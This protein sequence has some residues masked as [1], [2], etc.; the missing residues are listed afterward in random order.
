M[1]EP[2][3]EHLLTAPGEPGTVSLARVLSQV[4]AG[5]LAHGRESEKI[6]RTVPL[7]EHLPPSSERDREFAALQEQTRRFKIALDYMSQGLCLFDADKRLIIS[8]RRYAEIYGLSPDQIH[9]GMTLK[10]I[11]GLRAG[12]GSDPVLSYDEYINWVPSRDS[13]HSPTGMVVELKNGRTVAIRHQPLSDGGYVATHEDITE[14]LV[15][16]AKVAHMALHDSLTG[17]PNRVL[18]RDRLHQALVGLGKGQNCAVLYLDLD[19]FKTINDT[20]GHPLGDALLSAVSERLSRSIRK[21]DTVA[22][23]G[24]DEFA[25]VGCNLRFAAEA[26]YLA[27]RLIS[28]LGAPY[29]LNGHQV[30]IGTSI[31]IALAPVDGADPDQLMKHADLALYSAKLQ[32]RRRYSFFRPQMATSMEYRHTLEL[33]LRKALAAREF[34][35]HYQPLLDLRSGRVQGFEALLRWNTPERGLVSAREFIPLAEEIGLALPIGEWVLQQACIEAIDW[36]EELRVSVN[37]SSEQLKSGTL[38]PAIEAALSASG[39][40]ARRLE[41]EITETAVIQVPEA[42]RGML[43]QLK[44]SGIGIALDDFGTGYSSLSYI[45]DFPFDRIKIDRSFVRDLGHRPDSIAIVRAVIGLCSSLGKVATAEGVETEEQLAILR[46]EHCNEV[47][48]FLLGQPRPARAIPELLHL[49][50]IPN[51]HSSASA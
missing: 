14:R 35:L 19:Y 29:D 18:F 16:E 44:A 13:V 38:V 5:Y 48:G 7:A 43:H 40:P 49:D 10:E 1:R 31:G 22:R 37:V 23:L 6:V 30:V 25:I 47:Q 8:N 32:G 33:E 39:L 34:I 42:I 45:R 36:P 27:E 15:A 9:P 11:V 2:L 20:L 24:G 41:L 51:E 4:E 17:L 26:R 12:N 28:D 21:D 50:G 46:A 3:A